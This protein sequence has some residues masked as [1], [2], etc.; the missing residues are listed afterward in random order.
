M[1]PRHIEL[2]STTFFDGQT[3]VVGPVNGPDTVL[4]GS[5][6]LAPVAFGLIGLITAIVLIAGLLVRRRRKAAGTAKSKPIGLAITGGV[7]I[8]C[9]ALT[10]VNLP[11]QFFVPEFPALPQLL[12]E[13]AFF[14]RQVQDLPVSTK[15]AQW[16]G[17][18]GNAPLVPGF[19]GAVTDGVVYGVPFN[20]T[21]EQTPVVS[22]K[23]VLAPQT[24][25]PGP[26]PM[27]DPA[28]I[29]SMPTYGLDNHYVAVDVPAG[30]M[31]ELIGVR[32]WFG[33]WEA[34]AGAIW[35][36][37]SLEYPV[38]ST[39]AT[40][41]PLLPGLVTYDEV[42]AGEVQHVSLLTGPISH[43]QEFIW[44]A[45]ATDG[46]S[47]LPNAIPQGAWLRLKSGTDLS[48]LG[49][50]AAVVA[51]GLQRFG[52]LMSDTGPNWS[53][54]GT[55]DSRWDDA[56]LATLR[57]LDSSDF[58]VVETSGIRVAAGSMEAK[59]AS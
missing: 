23:A 2:L 13:Q 14:Y 32:C 16:I 21:S 44:P 24:T 27:A 53:V 38:G 1:G 26:Y 42:A 55:P 46:R 50:Q 49:K 52:M 8:L 19:S 11:P 29:E 34:D 6:Q 10:A 30:K 35:D 4:P 7:V 33:R 54:R 36:L 59:P 40:G 57:T 47:E 20:P 18:Q 25:P 31:W 15:S 3:N 58:E 45:R 12:P 9:G 17:S 48:G 56:D 39:T 28:Y 22:V 5:Q 41:V 37:D 43:S 51:R